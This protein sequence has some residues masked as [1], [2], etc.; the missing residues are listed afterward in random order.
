MSESRI[1]SRTELELHHVS[2]ELAAALDDPD[3]AR[4]LAV[5][6]ERL[7]P[8]AAD[9]TI[10]E[11][12]SALDAL[13]RPDAACAEAETRK[14][15]DMADDANAQVRAALAHAV[16]FPGRIRLWHPINHH[17]RPHS[18]VYASEAGD[19]YSQEGWWMLVD[20]ERSP[21]LD[22]IDGTPSAPIWLGEDNLEAARTIEK[23]RAAETWNALRAEPVREGEA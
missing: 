23:M 1:P 6:V 14:A 16:P 7:A 13:K 22:P 17:G 4:A 5:A 20:W 12:A 8:M 3:K 19:G 15:A 18:V 21:A 10:R 11:L 9:L 2:G